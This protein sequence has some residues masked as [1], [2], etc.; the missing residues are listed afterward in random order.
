MPSKTNKKKYC[1]YKIQR[2]K[3]K[4]EKCGKVCR[5][6][7]CFLHKKEYLENKAKKDKIY[8]EKKCEKLRLKTIEKNLNSLPSKRGKK[9]KVYNLHK[10]RKKLND[11]NYDIRGYK[12]RIYGCKLVLDPNFEAP[13]GYKCTIPE[14]Y[15]GIRHEPDTEEVE[16]HINKLLEKAKKSIKKR[17]FQTKLIALLE[18][19]EDS[20]DEIEEDE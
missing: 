10:E 5:G 1:I 14:C 6:N 8:N 12:N 15:V 18:G 19:P 20:D 3:R 13:D 4:D 11:M 9:K 2:G 16:K 17:D 7:F